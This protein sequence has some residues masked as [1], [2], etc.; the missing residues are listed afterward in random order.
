MLNKLN[1]VLSILPKLLTE[2][3]CKLLNMLNGLRQLTKHGKIPKSGNSLTSISQNFAQ[4]NYCYVLEPIRS[5]F[6]NLFGKLDH[7]IA[8]GKIVYNNQ[9]VLLTKRCINL[10]PKRFIGLA[11]GTIF[12]TLQFLRNLQMSP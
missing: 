11:S 1:K 2:L 6:H 4:N 5:K 7:F 9:T 8:M 10:V 3:L 12:P